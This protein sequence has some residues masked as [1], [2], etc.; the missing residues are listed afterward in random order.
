MVSQTVILAAGNGSRLVNGHGVPKPLMTIG[1]TPLVAHALEHARDSGCSEAVIV[2]GHEGERV[3]AAVEALETGLKVR[4]VE[5]PAP[6]APNGV[7]LLAAGPLA[8]SRF[9]L[10]MVD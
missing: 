7:F 1:G 4:F 6:P 3:K 5:G 9:F 10:Q 2:I 8:G